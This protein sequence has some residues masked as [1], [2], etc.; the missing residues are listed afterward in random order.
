MKQEK[1]IKAWAVGYK[2][3]IGLESL[4]WR[5][6]QES[7]G[8]DVIYPRIFM[9]EKGAKNYGK[10]RIDYKNYRVIPCEIKLLK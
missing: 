10:N 9:S 4:S 3:S 5:V 8:E 2:S 7:D 1:T 6:L